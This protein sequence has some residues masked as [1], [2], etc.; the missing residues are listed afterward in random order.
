MALLSVWALVISAV[1]VTIFHPSLS[2]RLAPMLCE[3]ITSGELFASSPPLR[4][5]SAFG[6]ASLLTRRSSSDGSAALSG[7]SSSADA[8]RGQMAFSLL[9]VIGSFD[10]CVERIRPA[11]A[12]GLVLSLFALVLRARLAAVVWSLYRQRAIQAAGYGELALGGAWLKG[13]EAGSAISDAGE[14]TEDDEAT[15]GALTPTTPRARSSAE[16]VKSSRW[17]Q[18]PS[19]QQQH[20][21]HKRA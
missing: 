5:S 19:P 14:E 18:V 4:P 20:A 17:L 2:P 16:P 1:S 13:D 12:F 11:L 8:H 3:E 15:V 10:Q 21:A 6:L 9:D 7:L